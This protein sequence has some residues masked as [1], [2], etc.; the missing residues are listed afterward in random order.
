MTGLEAVVLPLHQSHITLYGRE[1]RTEVFSKILLGLSQGNLTVMLK[2]IQ[3]T[4][5]KGYFITILYESN[6]T[7]IKINYSHYDSLTGI[8]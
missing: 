8:P 6:R 2:E 3:L 4:P 5:G 1:K 7:L